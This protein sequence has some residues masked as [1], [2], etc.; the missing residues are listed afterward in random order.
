M[1]YWAGCRTDVAAVG[2]PSPA[3][4]VRTA[5]WQPRSTCPDPGFRAGVFRRQTPRAPSA[6]CEQADAERSND[7]SMQL[8]KS[9]E[10]GEPLVE[11]HVGPSRTKR[12][13]PAYG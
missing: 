2:D 3:K 7:R 13:L 1:D 6:T 11:R 4:C 10:D 12:R 8:R 9:S 5:R